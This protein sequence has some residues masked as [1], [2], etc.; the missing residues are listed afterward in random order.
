MTYKEEV[1]NCFTTLDAWKENGLPREQPE[2]TA[3]P[4]LCIY[5]DRLENNGSI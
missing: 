3:L 4:Y 2:Q 5:T 1:I